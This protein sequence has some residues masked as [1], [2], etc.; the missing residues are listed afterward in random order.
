MS[1]I[2]E[3]SMHGT[4]ER[5]YDRESRVRRSAGTSFL[6][7]PIFLVIVVVA[8][9]IVQPNTS[10]WIAEAVQAEFVGD[11][12]SELSPTQL[13]QPAAEPRSTTSDWISRVQTAW[14]GQR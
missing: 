2:M 10:N 9:T 11:T 14:R 1:I 5:P 8:L 7:L 13:A 3:A 4:F 6:I 12:P